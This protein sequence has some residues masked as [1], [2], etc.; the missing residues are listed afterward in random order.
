[1]QDYPPAFL[2]LQ[3]NYSENNVVSSVITFND[4]TSVIEV[5]AIGGPAA[6]KWI[7]TGN[8]NPS[9]ITAVATIDLD[10]VVPTNTVRKFVI[11]IETQGSAS[12][13]GINKQAGLYNRMAV[14]TFGIASVITS[15]Y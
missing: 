12:V 13:V 1:M 11:P 10:H 8:T 15:Q 6:I 9:V 5:A 3:D 4:N 2:S 14:K 7:A